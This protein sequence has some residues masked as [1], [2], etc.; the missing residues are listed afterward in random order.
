[1]E[2]EIRFDTILFNSGGNLLVLFKDRSN[3][4]LNSISCSPVSTRLMDDRLATNQLQ[5]NGCREGGITYLGEAV[6]AQQ[7]SLPSISRKKYKLFE[8]KVMTQ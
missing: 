7:I 5:L 2:E 8:H 4:T 6:Q 1:M 3:T